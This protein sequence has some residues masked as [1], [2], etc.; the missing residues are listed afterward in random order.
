MAPDADANA[1]PFQ[2]EPD[3]QPKPAVE[4]RKAEPV[5]PVPLVFVS[6]AEPKEEAIAYDPRRSTPVYC[7]RLASGGCAPF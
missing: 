4:K 3:D 1:Q 6:R 7:Y 5:G 2:F